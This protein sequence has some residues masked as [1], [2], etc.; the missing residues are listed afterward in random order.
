MRWQGHVPQIFHARGACWGFMC[1]AN[2]KPGDL[3]ERVLAYV[4]SFSYNESELAHKTMEH[5]VSS[6]NL[7]GSLFNKTVV[8]TL[9]CCCICFLVTKWWHTRRVVVLSKKN[10]SQGF[11]GWREQCSSKGL[12]VSWKC[13]LNCRWR[14]FGLPCF[15]KSCG[16]YCPHRQAWDSPS[17]VVYKAWWNKAVTDSVKGWLWSCFRREVGVD[18]G[19]QSLPAN[20]SMFH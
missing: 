15:F 17:P 3:Q 8:T 6:W 1:N 11:R 19:Q 4:L 9:C 13:S 5:M 12:I 7:W 10:I 18:D 2:I 14:F 20:I 16:W